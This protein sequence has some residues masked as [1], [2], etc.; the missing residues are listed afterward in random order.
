M[1]LAIAS[2]TSLAP[3]RSEHPHSALCGIVGPI[4]RSAVFVVLSSHSGHVAI[5]G[6]GIPIQFDVASA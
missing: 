5:N 2:T 3:I 6:S 4:V 1:M